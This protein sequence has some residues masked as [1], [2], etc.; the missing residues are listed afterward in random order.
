MFIQRV[1]EGTGAGFSINSFKGVSNIINSEYMVLKNNIRLEW[2][3]INTHF[4][5]ICNTFNNIFYC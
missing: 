3:K 1:K 4:Y 5:N 2:K